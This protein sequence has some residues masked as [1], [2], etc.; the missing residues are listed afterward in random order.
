MLVRDDPPGAALSLPIRVVLSCEHAG[1]DV[2]RAYAHYFASSQAQAA[3]DSHRGWDPGSLGIG[4]AMSEVLGVPLIVQPVSRL[5][6]ECNR[7]LD[8][9]RLFSE[10][11]RGMSAQERAAVLDLYWRTH[12][13]R[14]VGQVMGG[15]SLVVH[16]GVHTFTPI[17][18]GRERAT[19]IGLLYDP[20]RRGEAKLVRAWRREMV[21]AAPPALRDVAPP[22]VPASRA[23]MAIHLNRPYRGWTDGLT[24]S[25]RK[26]L[27]EGRYVGVEL[28]VS[29]RLATTSATE[30]GQWIGSGLRA[31]LVQS[32]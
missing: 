2:P 28:E 7:S 5:L 16:V 9:P 24:T 11:S 4:E 6:V 29:Q 10:F 8:H 32:R 15:G 20:A 26:D 22:D 23:R 17:W 30:I 31:A 12:R 3:L 13:E 1:N 27:P 14:I 18:H 25:L 21:A 19:D